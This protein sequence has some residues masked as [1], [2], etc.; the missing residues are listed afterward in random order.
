MGRGA[1]MTL[2]NER[3]TPI[4]LFV[5][6]IKCVYYDDADSGSKLCKFALFT[7]TGAS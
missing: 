3:P 7:D 6:N 1:F 4:K 5:Q 2:K